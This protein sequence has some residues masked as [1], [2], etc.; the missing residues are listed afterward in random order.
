MGYD[1]R[2]ARILDLSREKALGLLGFPPDANPTEAELKAAQRKSALA[3]HPDRGGSVAQMQDVN[4]AFD[5][6][7]NAP[8]RPF[9]RSPGWS[10]ARPGP[11]DDAHWYGGGQQKAPDPVKFTFEQA[12][13]QANVPSDVDWQFV[14]E[15]QRSPNNYSGDTTYYKSAFVAYGRKVDLHIFAVAVY[16]RREYGPGSAQADKDIWY[17]QWF[18]HVIK[19]PAKES[20][21][22]GWLTAQVVKA[23]KFPA[24]ETSFEGKFNNKVRDAKGWKFKDGPPAG[25]STSIKH[26]LVESGQVA[27]DAPS[28]SKRKHVIELKL[29]KNPF[30]Q[31]PGYFEAPRTRGNFW[32]NKYH[33]DY[34]KFTLVIN[35]KEYDLNKEETQAF[36]GL[37]IAG[38]PA[39][40]AIYGEYYYGGEKKNLTRMPK[41][42]NILTWMAEHFT[43]L[44]EQVVEVI[45]AAAAQMK[46]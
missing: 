13:A 31:K 12:S 2:E 21:N 32:D 29:E 20:Q 24:G 14:T 1:F 43:G 37:K 41:G 19:D 23:L 18:R 26:W 16:F 39:L 11:Q 35:G 3:V 25:N 22:P 36:L 46:G 42:K 10:P 45:C 4:R 17:V 30:E 27:G 33:G 8:S 40:S 9:E 6:L 15:G 28:V 7:K 44:P 34:F 5:F 38:K